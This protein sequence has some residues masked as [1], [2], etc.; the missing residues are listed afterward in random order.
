MDWFKG[1][2]KLENPMILMI[3]VCGLEHVLFFNILEIIIPLTNI[4]QRG[5]N[6]QPGYCKSMKIY[7][8][9]VSIFPTK[10]IRWAG[11]SACYWRR[12][13][14]RCRYGSII[15][16]FLYGIYVK[17]TRWICSP[18]KLI[19]TRLKLLS[20]WR[21]ENPRCSMVLEY[22]PTFAVKSTQM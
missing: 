4:F 9:P 22:L 15:G 6:H 10:P 21:L 12:P 19:V 3:L 16:G 18:L 11:G 13:H 17:S 5:R 7:G 20:T 1:T 14:L 8:F 2:L